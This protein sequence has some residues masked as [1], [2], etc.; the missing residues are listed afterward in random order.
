LNSYQ[1]RGSLIGW[2]RTILAQRHVDQHRRTWRES[3]LSDLTENED[4]NDY[5]PPA[6]EPAPASTPTELNALSS[7][8]ETSLRQLSGEER[9]LLA[10]YYLDG[11]TLLQIA[12]MLQIHEATVSRKLR[13]LTDDLRKQVLRNLQ[14][15]G[16]S[17][18]AAQEALGA[19]PRDL[20][21]NLK[22]LLQSSQSEAFSEKAGK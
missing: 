18:R 6:P 12:R 8:I 5:D 9:F 16:L 13:R 1:G 17:R 2:L 3:S 19:D 22:K 21:L 7:A 15:A 10:S 4:A 14:G 11:Q 20:D